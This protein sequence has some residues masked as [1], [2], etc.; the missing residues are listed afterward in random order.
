MSSITEAV[1]TTAPDIASFGAGG[2]MYMASMYTGFEI[3]GSKIINPLFAFTRNDSSPANAAALTNLDEAR[4]IGSTMA[5]RAYRI[6]FRIVCFK[7]GSV[8]DISTAHAQKML[9]SGA[10]VTL[11]VGSNETKIA[12]FS[13]LDLMQPVD[14]VSM[15][16]DNANNVTCSNVGGLGGGIGW[17]PLQIPIEIQANCNV[18]GVVRF[19]NTAGI[20]ALAP[21]NESDPAWYGFVVIL[22]GLKVVKS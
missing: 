4:K 6:G 18:G 5:F 20:N 19:N 14:T 12:E 22:Q 9:L 1:T 8:P 7:G 10:S 13:G 2:Q 11:T 15:D 16:S 3:R 17:I 21:V